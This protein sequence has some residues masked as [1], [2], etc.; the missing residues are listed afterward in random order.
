MC[1]ALTIVMKALGLIVALVFVS[2]AGCGPLAPPAPPDDRP[3]FSRD[4]APLLEEHCQSCHRVDG[5]APFPLLT[6]SDAEHNAQAIKTAVLTRRMPHGLSVRMDDGCAGPTTFRGPR[7]LMQQEIDTLVAWVD[8]GCAEGVALK[9]PHQ[10][11]LEVPRWLSQEPDLIAVNDAF[12]FTVPPNLGRDIFRRFV[13]EPNFEADRFLTGFEVLPGVTGGERLGHVVH[14]VTLFIDPEH[15]SPE[16]LRQFQASSPAVPGPGFEGDFPYPTAMVGMWFPGS[17][18][19][20]LGLGKGLRI[21]AGAAVVIEIHYGRVGE[22]VIDQTQVCLHIVDRVSEEIQTSL[23]KNEDIFI[24]A[25]DKAAVIKASRTFANDFTL[26]AITPHMHQLGTGFRVL[27]SMPGAQVCLANVEWDFEHQGSSRL[28]TPMKIPAGSTIRTECTYDNSMEN[29][30]QPNNPPS[31]VVFGK[32]TDR[33]MCQLTIA[34][35]PL[36]AAP[37]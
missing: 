12:G 22:A 1:T 28:T 13:F 20:T 35:S 23:V 4:V 27:V 34:T 21:P 26:Y 15:K 31:D 18:P 7:R 37:R 3:T 8:D 32:S 14:H 17:A 11:Q 19:V 10:E 24:P 2:L 29:K 25:G 9:P 30:N 6:F 16:Q 33:E 36:A 5:I